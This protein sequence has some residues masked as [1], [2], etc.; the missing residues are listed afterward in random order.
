MPP[1]IRNWKSGRS[2]ALVAAALTL[3]TCVSRTSA[4]IPTRPGKSPTSS[5]T[6]SAS[7]S[8]S[9]SPTPSPFTCAGYAPPSIA[10]EGNLPSPR[11]SAAFIYDKATDQTIL[12]GGDAGQSAGEIPNDTWIW[13][14]PAWSQTHPATAPPCWRS[15]TTS[16]FDDED[17]GQLWFTEPTPP[18]RSGATLAYDGHRLILFG[19]LHI[20]SG[21][22]PAGTPLNGTWAF[23]GTHWQQLH[24]PSSAPARSGAGLLQQGP[25]GVVII[26]GF[27]ETAQVGT[28][29]NDMWRW[30]GSNWARLP[31]SMP[32]PA[33]R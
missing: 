11:R 16:A 13:N 3:T 4:V 18:S 21:P 17:W 12:F 10:P 8:P 28:Y 32:G 14:G 9:A 30:D 7:P 20:S 29:Y 33:N 25:N 1:L 15:G 23:D 24:P 26:G 5:S 27:S 19:G 6:P 31:V 22:T 2:A